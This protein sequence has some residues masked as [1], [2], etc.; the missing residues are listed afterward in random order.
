MKA[1]KLPGFFKTT[2]GEDVTHKTRKTASIVQKLDI[3]SY[4]GFLVVSTNVATI[5]AAHPITMFDWLGMS[6]NG[7]ATGCSH[8]CRSLT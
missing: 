4:S 2:F 3:K 7:K 8:W 1:E 6:A 5:S